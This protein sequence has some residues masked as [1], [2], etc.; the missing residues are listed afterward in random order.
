MSIDYEVNQLRRYFF[1]RVLLPICIYISIIIIILFSI[2]F[3]QEKL[4]VLN[5]DIVN[6]YDRTS[7]RLVAINEL[8]GNNVT[9]NREIVIKS[10]EIYNFL[11]NKSHKMCDT[12]IIKPLNSLSQQNIANNLLNN[13]A[14]EM[15]LEKLNN[16]KKSG[17]VDQLQY[18]V[19][20]YLPNY[21]EYRNS[22]VILRSVD[23]NMFYRAK[24]YQ[25][26]LDIASNIR[27]I[28]PAKSI[29]SSFVLKDDE[30]LTPQLMLNQST[31]GALNVVTGDLL[32]S[33]RFVDINR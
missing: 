1:S 17:Y 4:D 3:L 18:S 24:T 7:K 25:N 22:A 6:N 33:T 12:D 27:D 21:K 14:N 20:R 13:D 26:V 2:T 5:N 9:Q 28:F 30:Y 23:V 10:N 16:F 29:I 15:Y 32:I 19:N 8:M 11:F 31:A